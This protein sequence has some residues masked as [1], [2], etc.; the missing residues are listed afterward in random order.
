MTSTQE[1]EAWVEAYRGAWISNDADEVAALFA[2]DAVYEFRPHDPDPWR[3]RDGIVAGWLGEQ[4]SPE[5]WKFEFQVLGIL[6]DGSALVRAVTEYLDDRPTFDNLWFI[7]FEGGKA[8][9]FT[10]WY[11]AREG[12]GTDE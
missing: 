12:T 7:T 2:D 3:G 8:S 1:V 5:T 9:R 6:D 4:D 10:E 11:M